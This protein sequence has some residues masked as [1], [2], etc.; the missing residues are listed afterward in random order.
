MQRGEGN[1]GIDIT[2]EEARL[3]AMHAII[4][5]IKTEGIPGWEEYPNL[6]ERA[7]W[8]VD[9]QID[10]LCNSLEDQMEELAKG[11]GINLKELLEATDE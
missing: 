8:K 4:V 3:I 5:G 11:H 1:G 2:D 10:A 6:T 9:G 7:W